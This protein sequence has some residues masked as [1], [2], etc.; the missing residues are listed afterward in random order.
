MAINCLGLY[1]S[2]MKP[3]G[4]AGLLTDGF[5]FFFMPEAQFGP[6]FGLG[7]G[8]TSEYIYGK[9][10]QALRIGTVD[11]A[12]RLRM[13]KNGKKAQPYILADVGVNSLSKTGNHWIGSSRLSLGI[14]TRLP[15]ALGLA[16]DLGAR[17]VWL[18]PKPD[19]LQYL[20]IECGMVSEFDFGHHS[21]KA[22]PNPTATV[23][24]TPKIVA[25]VSSSPS[26]T[27][28]ATFSAKPSMPV[29][30][31]EPTLIRV[32]PTSTPFQTPTVVPL[33]PTATMVASE[34]KARMLENYKKGIEAYKAKKYITATSY[35]KK[36]VI[37]QEVDTEYW[38]YAEAYAMLG[39]I[40][41]YHRT[42]PGHLETARRYYKAAL[43]ID[44][45]T[46]TAKKGLSVLGTS[47]TQPKAKSLK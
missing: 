45:R 4:K 42:D 30:T 46:T 27:S 35:L 2:P 33:A 31:V 15:V 19:D 38:Y 21:D 39:A 16:L 13:P 40:Y 41:Q 28:T 36:A 10:G 44:P 20:S 43:K 24:T 6:V 26:P 9:S 25:S 1:D 3:L 7:C 37:I 29:F 12:T 14:G 11:F 34:A 5:G 8:F 17:Q 47:A 22:T 18:F 32:R 23:V